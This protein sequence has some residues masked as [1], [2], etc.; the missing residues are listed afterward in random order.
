MSKGKRATGLF[1]AAVATAALTVPVVAAADYPGQS[2]RV[3]T[4][5]SINPYGNAGKVLAPN[6]NCVEGRKVV[7]KQVGVGK[8]G[9]AE[10]TASG[11]WSAEPRYKG[12]LPFK[13]YAEVKPVT[14]GTAGTIYKC[15]G[16]TSEV[17]TINGG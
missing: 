7:V 6:E 12:R 1:A 10:V 15:L 5:I 17:R 2:V 16:A 4:T 13:V 9:S 14:Q 11:G 3:Q 8:I